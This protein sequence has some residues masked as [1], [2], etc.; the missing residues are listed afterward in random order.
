MIRSHHRRLVPCV[1]ALLTLCVVGGL[2][3][4]G[5]GELPPP[6]GDDP[7]GSDAGPNTGGDS[8]SQSGVTFPDV[9]LDKGITFGD[10]GFT[11]CGGQAGPQTI[12]L[13]N[14]TSEIVN[15]TAS[16]GGGSTMYTVSPPT[17]G[18][19]AR[20]TALI[21]ITPTAIPKE[22]DVRTDLYAA[23]L[24][25]K[26]PGRGTPT[27]IRL[28]QTARGA[29]IA[30]TGG[31][32]ID[33]G[34]VKVGD[35]SAIPLSITNSGNAEVTASLGLGTTVFTIGGGP[36]ASIVLALFAFSATEPTPTGANVGTSL[37][38]LRLTV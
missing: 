9:D 12:T 38:P 35:E 21:Q 30:L 32:Q 2:V 26:F 29:I 15:F 25:V 13:K 31:P 10:N 19:P 23:T 36:T 16:V 27:Q 4:C 33:F 7:T 20:G 11:D 18:V 34:S 1:Q 5:G 3:H 8:G 28:H 6:A 14:S 22:S 24:E 37:P 17:G